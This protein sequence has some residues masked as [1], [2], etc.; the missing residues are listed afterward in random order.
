MKKDNTLQDY[1]KF[2]E[3]SNISKPGTGTALAL[4]K[5]ALKGKKANTK[6]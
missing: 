5:E 6:A 1:V 3:K 2:C 4:Y